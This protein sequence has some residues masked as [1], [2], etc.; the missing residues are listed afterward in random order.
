MNEDNVIP[1]L[2]SPVHAVGRS[3]ALRDRSRR[4]DERGIRREMNGWYEHAKKIA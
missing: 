2:S 4:V 3:E 1:Y